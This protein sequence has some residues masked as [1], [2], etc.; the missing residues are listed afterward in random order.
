MDKAYTAFTERTTRHF[1]RFGQIPPDGTPI[2][3]PPRRQ[4]GLAGL[5][6]DPAT[7][8]R[9]SPA[10]KFYYFTYSIYRE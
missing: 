2:L 8:G 9:G 6:P 5:T 1:V 3:P 7:A 4:T 10:H